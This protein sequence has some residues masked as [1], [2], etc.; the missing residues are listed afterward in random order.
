[1]ARH[2][3][4]A[5]YPPL[6]R[7]QFHRRF[8]SFIL[9]RHLSHHLSFLIAGR[10]CGQ[11]GDIHSFTLLYSHSF[12]RSTNTVKQPHSLHRSSRFRATTAF[13]II[14]NDDDDFLLGSRK[15]E[16]SYSIRVRA[17]TSDVRTVSGLGKGRGKCELGHCRLRPGR[18]PACCSRNDFLRP[19]G[20]QCSGGLQSS[21]PTTSHYNHSACAKL[22]PV[23]QRRR[24]HDLVLRR[25]RASHRDPK[26]LRKGSP[27]SSANT[28]DGRQLCTIAHGATCTVCQARG[29]TGG[30]L[31][32]GY[33]M[34]NA[35]GTWIEGNWDTDAQ[36][37]CLDISYI[38]GYSVPIQCTGSDG[39]SKIGKMDALCTDEACSNCASGGGTYQDGACLNPMG[40]PDTVLVDGPPPTFFS[41][42]T[43]IIYTY[44]NDNGA[45]GYST[46]WNAAKCVA[47]PQAGSSSNKREVEEPQAEESPVVKEKREAIR[48]QHVQQ[49]QASKR[50]AAH[51]EHV[52]SHLGR[53]NNRQRRHAHGHGL[54]GGVS[55]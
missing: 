20:F 5:A 34:P 24:H 10:L 35:R 9:F 14:F 11:R 45:V 32:L 41:P 39:T 28:M 44:P 18:W 15:D 26:H 52:H 27:R 33:G 46:P 51:S 12:A 19:G 17:A 23:W 55:T 50:E 53:R 30:N 4:P 54:V 49:A 37:P 7:N 38:P 36:F 13:S 3:V 2:A 1:M 21:K 25:R 22:F 31:Q 43:G 8:D 47:G 6:H 29:S 40:S 48:L 16:N 42:V